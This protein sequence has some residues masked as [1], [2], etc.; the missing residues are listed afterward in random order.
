[1]FEATNR[2]KKLFGISESVATPVARTDVANMDSY[3]VWYASNG[4]KSP[5]NMNSTALR[6]YCNVNESL[7]DA[8][9][10]RLGYQLGMWNMNNMPSVG[11]PY[12]RDLMGK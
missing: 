8:G 9:Y 6:I 5:I 2:A 10:F 1:M 3:K 4:T 7:G 12:V 11:R